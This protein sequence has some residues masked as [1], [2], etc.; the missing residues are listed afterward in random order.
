MS[1]DAETRDWT[2]S[3]GN[4]FEAIELI[5][6]VCEENDLSMPKS[7]PMSEIS[8]RKRSFWQGNRKIMPERL[9]ET[10]WKPLYPSFRTGLMA[11][12]KEEEERG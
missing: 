7:V 12:W 9:K 11:S 5:R 10:G 4:P 1:L 6:F 2:V 3:D 8:P